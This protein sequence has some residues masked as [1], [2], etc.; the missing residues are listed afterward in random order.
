MS[1]ITD[2]PVVVISEERG[3]VSL[4]FNGELTKDLE[5]TELRKLL[6]QILQGYE[7]KD[8]STEPQPDSRPAEG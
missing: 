4:A 1:V 2:A 5:E 3:K 8:A 7:L 6:T